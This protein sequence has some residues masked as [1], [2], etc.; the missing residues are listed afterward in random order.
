MAGE[1][2]AIGD[3]VE[4]WKQGDRVCANLML[5]HVRGD[6]TPAMLLNA[7]G[8]SVDGVL[9]EYRAFP[10]HVRPRSGHRIFLPQSIDYSVSGTVSC[11]GTRAFVL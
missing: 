3:G 5:D 4:K 1:V 8:S 6:A 9:T 10:A 2:V 11:E 7:L